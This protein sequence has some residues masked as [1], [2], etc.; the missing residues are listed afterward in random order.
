MTTWRSFSLLR[1]PSRR[2]RVIPATFSSFVPLI[3]WLSGCSV[4]QWCPTSKFR[5]IART[6]APR[7][8]DSLRFHLVAEAALILP[9]G[10]GHAWLGSRR[11]DLA[12]GVKN[13]AL[14]GG[15]GVIPISRR[16][17]HCVIVYLITIRIHLDGLAVKLTRQGQELGRHMAPHRAW[18]ARR[19]GGDAIGITILR[20]GSWGIGGRRLHH[21]GLSVVLV[22]GHGACGCA[23][24]S[25]GLS[26]GHVR[27]NI[28]IRL[29]LV[30]AAEGGRAR[31]VSVVDRRGETVFR[32]RIQGKATLG[33]RDVYRR[34]PGLVDRQC[35]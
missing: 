26:R 34:T 25:V 9:Q 16:G 21:R 30:H 17:C 12:G 5:G 29:G 7:H 31:I 24:R 22:V 1:I 2:P 11:G 28:H 13:E 19:W 18:W 6:L 8:A 32:G 23:L 15:T 20:V 14:E 4:S 10:G 33:S 27:V 3:M 35:P